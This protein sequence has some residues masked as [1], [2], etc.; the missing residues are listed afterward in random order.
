MNR[1]ACSMI[2]MLGPCLVL[3][4]GQSE[5]PNATTIQDD[6][7][8]GPT[9][10]DDLVQTLVNIDMAG[11]FIPLQVRPEE[12]ALGL[13]LIDQEHREGAHEVAQARRLAIGMLLVDNIDVV[14]EASDAIRAGEKDKAQAVYR[15]L[16]D[17]F[18]PD[19]VRDPLLDAWKDVLSEQEVRQIQQLVDE[20]WDACIKWE[21]RN[22]HDPSD[23]ARK[24]TQR[25]L[26]FQ[27]FRREIGEA[28]NWSLRPIQQRL[29]S[30]Y[31]ATEPTEEQRSAIR[32][33]MIDYIRESLLRPTP[34]QRQTAAARI[35]D[36]LNEKQRLKLFE[37]ALW[38]M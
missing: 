31:Q 14:K 27:L 35:Y 9:V 38:Q 3:L 8:R 32:D 4:G 24:K 29:E 13:V 17:Q 36:L 37:Q 11:K 33:V 22:A 15:Q 7:L 23:T 28:Y 6:L 1:T 30:I 16:H 26:S 18:N 20:Y 2:A 10:P 21:L 19:H 34:E 25:R 5:P 12:A